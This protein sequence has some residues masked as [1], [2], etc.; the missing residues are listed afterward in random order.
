MNESE[1][2]AELID[3]ALAAAGWGV[4]AGSRIR[5]EQICPGRIQSGGR[6]ANP[7]FVDY[8]LMF[9]GKKLAAIEA[10]SNDK[11]VGEGVGQAKDY[12]V[13]LNIRTTFSA[14]GKQIYQICM[15]TGKEGLVERF[16]TPDELWQATFA[17]ENKWRNEFAA[18]PYNDVVVPSP[19]VSIRKT[20]LMR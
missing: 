15:Q 4:V 20:R 11:E 17:T 12:A 2:R 8:I 9:R 14:N 18:E 10:K 13:K 6:R 16:P 7:L 3:P 19:R 1:T 5:R